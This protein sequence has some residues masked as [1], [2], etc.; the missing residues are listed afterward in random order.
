LHVIR[1]GKEIKKIL[2]L[3]DSET[4][5]PGEYH[6]FYGI[7]DSCIAEISTQHFEDDSYRLTQSGQGIPPQFPKQGEQE[8]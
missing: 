5:Y 7:D 8:Q 4:I 3:G 6:L 2:T 1:D